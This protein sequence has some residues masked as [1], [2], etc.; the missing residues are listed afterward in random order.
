[1]LCVGAAFADSCNVEWTRSGR[2]LGC[3]ASVTGRG[4]VN[5]FAGLIARFLC[6][7]PMYT[8]QTHLVTQVLQA[9]GA[10][11]LAARQRLWEIVYQEL[12]AMAAARLAGE[13]PGGV[14]ATTLVH[15]AYLRL[16][17]GDNG[18]YTSR[19]HFFGAAAQAMRR[20]LVDHAR[21]RGAVKRGGAGHRLIAGATS[22]E[23]G[24][25]QS[26]AHRLEAGA[27]GFEPATFD[28]DPAMM[29][30]LEEALGRL[31]A[32]H[33]RAAEVV[34]LRF[35]AGLTVDQT[36]EM[37]ELAPRTVDSEWRMARAWLHRALG[38][39]A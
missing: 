25:T 22:G 2:K 24:A 18:H 8:E 21:R 31:E 13:R 38:G 10:G 3:I 39:E 1:M 5:C 19:R 14:Q 12:K 36:A 27:T 30:A 7:L 28:G 6:G 15:E 26:E 33:P 32:L 11:D 34:H 37:M 4:V 20:I 16:F 23:S 35:F 17:G 9:V 29:L